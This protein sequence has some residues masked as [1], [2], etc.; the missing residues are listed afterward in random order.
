MT[1][2]IKPNVHVVIS[3][4]GAAEVEKFPAEETKTIAHKSTKYLPARA[5]RREIPRGRNENN[6]TQ[7]RQILARA[8]SAP[9]AGSAPREKEIAA[10]G[11]SEYSSRY[12]LKRKHEKQIS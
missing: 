5:P 8:G 6:R 7:K 2:L 4:V 12:D 11:K 3:S 9:Y 1:N 10:Y